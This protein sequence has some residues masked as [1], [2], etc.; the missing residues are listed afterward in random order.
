MR[1][2]T[3][4][5]KGKKRGGTITVKTEEGKTKTVRLYKNI[6]KGCSTPRQICI[7]CK[8]TRIPKNSKLFENK[9]CE[10]CVCRFKD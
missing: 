8:K 3:I 6:P 4:G 2:F 5:R 10:D 7:R 1:Q 9:V